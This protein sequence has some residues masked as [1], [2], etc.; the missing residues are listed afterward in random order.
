MTQSG[1]IYK[2]YCPTD[3]N[4]DVY[5]GSSTITHRLLNHK[6]HYRNWKDGI[7]THLTSFNLFDKYGVDNCILEV[8]E[9]VMYNDITELRERERYYIDNFQC[10]NIQKPNRSKKQYAIDRKDYLKEKAKE[11]RIKNEVAIKQRK[12]LYNDTHKEEYKEYALKNKAK[13]EQKINCECGATH[14]WR[15]AATH[16]KTKTHLAYLSTLPSSTP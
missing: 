5:Y 2:L 8:I 11:N 4:S 1:Y 9:N 10:I 14:S 16:K 12:K 6:V 15:N 3:E 13:W 7:K